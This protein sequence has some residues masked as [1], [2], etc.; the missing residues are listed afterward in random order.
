M[1]REIGKL[2]SNQD[3][4]SFVLYKCQKRRILNSLV[5]TWQEEHSGQSKQTF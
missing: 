5:C 4:N 3:R 2:N 1:T